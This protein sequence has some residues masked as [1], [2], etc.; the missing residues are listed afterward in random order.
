MPSSLRAPK[1]VRGS[2]PG[3]QEHA[4]ARKGGGAAQI[5]VG[6]F[7]SGMS[8]IYPRDCAPPNLPPAEPTLIPIG[9]ISPRGGCRQRRYGPIDPD[10][11][12][13]PNCRSRMA[14]FT[15]N[16]VSS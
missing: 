5:D 16:V 15:I 13:S 1:T 6:T 4:L 2:P 12:V 3:K 7:V 11:V 14:V 10:A 9:R 8:H